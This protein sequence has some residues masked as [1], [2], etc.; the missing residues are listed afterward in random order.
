MADGGEAEAAAPVLAVD[1]D[2]TLLRSDMLHET[3]LSACTRNKA[4]PLLALGALLKG[5]TALK[6]K[7]A[8]LAEIDPAT[9]PYNRDVLAKIE[10]WKARGARIVLVTATVQPLAE[11]VA[12]HLG[13][14]DEVYGSDGRLNLKGQEKAQLLVSRFGERGFAYAGNSA[15]DLP[16]WEKSSEAI[17]LGS[18][19]LCAR[20]ASLAPKIVRIEAGGNTAA[21]LL[22][23]MRPHQWLKNLLVFIPAL[24]AHRFDAA[25]LMA[26][27]QAFI[28]FCLIASASYLVNDLLDL[29]AD[30][31]HPWKRR[32]PFAAGDASIGSGILLALVALLSGLGLAA[33]LKPDFLALLAFYFALTLAYSLWLKHFAI[34]DICVLSGLYSLR[35]FGGAVMTGIPVSVW[36]LAFSIFFFLSL[37]AVKRQAEL[38]ASLAEGNGKMWARGY[39]TADIP[40]VGSLLVASGMV[41]VLVVVLYASSP[42][43]RMLYNGP[44]WLLGVA[45]VLLYWIARV[46]MMT[47]RG[48]MHDDPVVFAAKDPISYVCMA[49]VAAFLVA[50]TLF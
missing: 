41:S 20:A 39:S 13:H 35:I 17:V 31:R 28:G 8:A 18:D 29:A 16:V 50:G 47:H 43:V 15:D 25:T 33:S 7:L 14:F 40:L 30:R 10:E 3:F 5:R 36:L 37:A 2:G 24:A 19:K 49:L 22:R 4:A 6:Q 46:A 26:S 42:P 12:R 1:L 38:V 48:Q 9:L 44:E 27:L 32:R 21:A 34:V 45:F 11:D 23:A